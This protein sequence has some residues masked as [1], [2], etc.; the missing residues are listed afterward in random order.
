MIVHRIENVQFSLR[1]DN[2]DKVGNRKRSHTILEAVKKDVYDLPT[3]MSL[4]HAAAT[5]ADDEKIRMKK[6]KQKYRKV[7][8]ESEYKLTFLNAKMV[9]IVNY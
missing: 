1:S 3:A 4:T 7:V 2:L 6:V 5:I 9:Y 8:N